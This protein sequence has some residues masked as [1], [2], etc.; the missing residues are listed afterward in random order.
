MYFD[1]CFL[2]NMYLNLSFSYYLTYP[3]YLTRTLMDHSSRM[4]ILIYAFC[5]KVI[6]DYHIP[7]MDIFYLFFLY[8]AYIDYDTYF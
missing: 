3:S 5:P 8:N 2:S 4:C 6:L 1:H 7:G